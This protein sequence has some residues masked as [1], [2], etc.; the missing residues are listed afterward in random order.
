MKYPGAGNGSRQPRLKV[1]IFFL[2]KV[3]SRFYLKQNV[4]FYFHQLRFCFCFQEFFARQ[5]LQY[6]I[7]RLLKE[8]S[9]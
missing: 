9:L 1:A 6:Q 8:V 3:F 2:S 5:K 4:L 7:N